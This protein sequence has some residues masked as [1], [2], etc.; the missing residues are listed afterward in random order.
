[1]LRLLQDYDIISNSMCLQVH[2]SINPNICKNGKNKENLKVFLMTNFVG[3]FTVPRVIIKS[4][5][6]N[7][8][9]NKRK[10]KG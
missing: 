3:I 4:H 9:D 10:G 7:G 6:Q 5:S 8:N 1:M 2:Y